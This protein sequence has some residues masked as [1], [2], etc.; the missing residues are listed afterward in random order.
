MDANLGGSSGM[1]SLKTTSTEEILG[2][3]F[4]PIQW[5]IPDY[6]PPGMT[7]INGDP[8]DGVGW[9][10]LQ[11][12]KE[13]ACGGKMFGKDMEKR[14]VLYLELVESRE[15]IHDR[16]IRQRWGEESA[17]VDVMF[18]DDFKEQ[19]GAM[20]V[21]GSERLLVHIKKIGYQMVIINT[22]RRAIQAKKV[23]KAVIDFAFDSL[24]LYAM[25]T[26][27]S[28]IIVDNLTEGKQ[29]NFWEGLYAKAAGVANTFWFLYRE[30]EMKRRVT[31]LLVVGRDI[32][33]VILELSLNKQIY[34]W[35]CVS[36]EV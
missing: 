14:R 33:D 35:E 13:A 5:V 3:V 6:L 19:I 18:Y 7:F 2:K 9:L 12:A 16:A 25:K 36:Q 11:L 27:V 17:D 23:D 22:L 20:D 24:S 30:K 15:R 28:V 32:Y 31:K 26:D 1:G 34:S 4:P 10:S 21:R 29:E 8:E